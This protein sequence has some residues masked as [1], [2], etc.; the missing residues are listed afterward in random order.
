[1]GEQLGPGRIADVEHGEPA[2]AS[3]G[4]G[5]VAGDESVVQRVAS[6]L[7]PTRRL[8]A[9]RPHARDPPICRRPRAGSAPPCRRSPAPGR[10]IPI[11]RDPA[12]QEGGYQ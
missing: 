12:R 5:E 1:M 9:V 6:P 8:A 11:K 2:V 7:W 10:R 4:I 3:G